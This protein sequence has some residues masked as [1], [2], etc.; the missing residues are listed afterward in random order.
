MMIDVAAP[1]VRV[2]LLLVEDNEEDVLIV[3]RMLQ[4]YP[5]ARF[6]II[7]AASVADAA[8]RLSDGSA[9]VVLL[10]NGLPGDRGVELLH[11]LRNTGMRVPVIMLTGQGDEFLAR[12]AMNL[13]AYDYLPKHV[14]SSEMLGHAVHQAVEKARIEERLLDERLDGAEAVIF[15]LA[16]AAEEKDPLTEQHLR[17]MAIYAVELGKAL[18]LD[19]RQLLLLRYGAILHDIGK[20]GVSDTILAKPGPLTDEEWHEMRRHPAIGDRICTPLR[21]ADEIRPIVRHHHERWD[22]GGYVD[23]LRE[24]EIPFLAR[25]VSVVD[26]FD[27]MS[28][29]RPYR[30]AMPRDEVLRRLGAGRGTQ[31]DPRILDAFMEVVRQWPDAS[32]LAA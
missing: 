24:D 10:D 6:E 1:P 7:E 5:R 25:I 31:F 12:E 27:A 28:E 20:I 17:R 2:R 23:G 3:R 13:G 15:A 30:S 4:R 8:G 32:P 21:L 16:A 18:E 19:D 14:I 11:W 29:D 9:D 22:G 26:S